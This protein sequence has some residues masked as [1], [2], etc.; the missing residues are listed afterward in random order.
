MVNNDYGSISRLNIKKRH[1]TYFITLIK[2]LLNNNNNNNN[3]LN[4]PIGRGYKTFIKHC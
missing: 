4:L 1:L 3:L 2:Q